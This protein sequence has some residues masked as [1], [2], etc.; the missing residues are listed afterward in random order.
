[1]NRLKNFSYL[2]AA[3]VIGFSGFAYSQGGVQSGAPVVGG[4]AYCSSYVNGVCANTVPAGPT[5]VTGDETVLAQT[6]LTQGRNPQVV[7][8]SM[9]SLNS[10]PL[11]LHTCAA[12]ACGNV[13][14]AGNSGGVVL[15]YSTTIDSATV[16]LPAL[17]AAMIGQ[18]VSIGASHTVT[19]LTVSAGAG[20]SLAVTTP[21][22]L[23]ASTTAPQGYEFVLMSDTKWYR[24]R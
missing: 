2:L 23:T 16:I 21:T 18:R 15:T 12:A 6:N 1:M 17:T 22:A 20:T 9:R 11:A 13:T 24:V 3:L 4:A 19:A 7:A 8:M 14:I 10:A 5:A